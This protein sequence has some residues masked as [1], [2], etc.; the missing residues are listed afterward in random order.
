MLV[1]NLPWG[2]AVGL[3][4][5]AV[6][7]FSALADMQVLESNVSGI[8]VGSRLPDNL[9]LDLPIGGRVKVL[10]LPSNET[11]IFSGPPSRDAPLGGMRGPPKSQ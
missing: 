1:R 5:L 10:L 7:S 3:I 11:K 6:T 8:Q 4:G 9:K 2:I